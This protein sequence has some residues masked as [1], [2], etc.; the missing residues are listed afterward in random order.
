M[1][2]LYRQSY[3]HE[4]FLVKVQFTK[5]RRKER[6]ERK[7][8]RKMVNTLKIVVYFPKCLVT[9]QRKKVYLILKR[10][11]LDGPVPVAVVSLEIWV[12][13]T[14]TSDSWAGSLGW[15]SHLQRATAGTVFPCQSQ[16]CHMQSLLRVGAVPC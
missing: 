9:V 12:H 5:R 10:C 3:K 15:R 11:T 16:V 13:F 8:G 2:K 4:E 7:E 6:K 1:E 14:H